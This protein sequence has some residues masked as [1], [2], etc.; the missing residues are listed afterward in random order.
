MYQLARQRYQTVKDVQQVRVIKG[1]DGSVLALKMSTL[2]GGW[3]V[4]RVNQE[5][6]MIRRE[7]MRVAMMRTKSGKADGPGDI[8]GNV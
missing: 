2:S 4:E 8:P 1:R 3:M 7:E 5:E 6:L